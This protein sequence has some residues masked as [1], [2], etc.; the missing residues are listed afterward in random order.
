MKYLVILFIKI[1]FILKKLGIKIRGL[2]RAQSMLKKMF[3]F[4]FM[5]C[6]MLYMPSIAGSYDYLLV[7]QSNEP[8]TQIFLTNLAGTKLSMNFV[9]VGASIGEFVFSM[10]RFDNI[11]RIF[12]FE[13]RPDCAS[14]LRLNVELNKE[15]RIT[16]LEQA[17][18]NNNGVIKF[19]LKKSGTSSSINETTPISKEIVVKSV[20]LDSILPMDLNLPIILIDVE[21]AENL[22]IEGATNFINQTLP[23]IIFEFNHISRKYFSIN[24]IKNL[25]G[26]DY[27]IFRLRKD[28]YLDRELNSTWNCIAV[29]NKS[30]FFSLIQ[31]LILSN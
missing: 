21:G 2:G 31:P 9:D 12:A 1:H 11:E 25:L 13:P 23:L 10:S 20:R 7:G 14:V 19:F 27:M 17:A 24:N 26:N 22:V 8:E 3:V 15:K 30:D 28:G 6:N 29:S 18:S 4:S 16:V 5:D